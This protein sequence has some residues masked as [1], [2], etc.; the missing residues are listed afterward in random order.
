METNDI[1]NQI[2]TLDLEQNPIRALD[3]L[4]G[5]RATLGQS[6]RGLEYLR[7]VCLALSGQLDEAL[8]AVNVEIA[9]YPDNERALSLREKLQQGAISI[10]TSPGQGGEQKHLKSFNYGSALDP[11][12]LPK[13][14]DSWQLI[15][16]L[17]PTGVIIEPI[18]TCN[19]TCTYCPH[20]VMKRT[21]ERMPEE[22]VTRLLD[23]LGG[24]DYSGSLSFQY[25]NEPLLDKRLDKFLRYARKACPKI[26]LA[27][28]TNG[29][30]LTADRA[31]S[32]LELCDDIRITQHDEVFSREEELDTFIS[33]RPELK[34]RLTILRPGWK[35]QSWGGII[36]HIKTYPWENFREQCPYFAT[37]IIRVDG[38]SV[39]CCQDFNGQYG[40]GSVYQHSLQELWARAE[41][42]RKRLFLGTH[43]RMKICAECTGTPFT[44]AQETGAS[45][46]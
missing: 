8:N 12:T 1:L 27:I 46:D 37:L 26:K 7:A 19:R 6:P 45:Y 25:V 30:L 40:F 13:T 20:G 29:D 31:L 17:P 24:W 9:C 16:D 42:R 34:S 39:L 21:A 23:E 2:A 44:G 33:Q 38:E 22:V 36:K 18:S 41:P 4:N 3:V 11:A 5:A 14:E 32:L 28:S 10:S 15:K 43:V 35:P